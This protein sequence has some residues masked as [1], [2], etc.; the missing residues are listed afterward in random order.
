MV[1]IE[2]G[3]SR[4]G[5]DATGGWRKN[6]IL[7]RVINYSSVVLDLLSTVINMVILNLAS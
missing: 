5:S 1:G 3:W 7:L 6:D 4:V 2:V